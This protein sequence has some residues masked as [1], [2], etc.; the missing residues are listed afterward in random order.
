MLALLSVLFVMASA[1]F[2]FGLVRAIASE[3]PPLD[4]GRQRG[5]DELDSV[6]YDSNAASPRVLAVL[7][8]DESRVL[9]RTIDDVAPL[10]RQAIVAVEDQ[11]FYEHRGV[12]LRGIGRALWQ[13]I[14]KQ[15]VVEGG[16]TITQQFVKNAYV[17]NERTIGRKVREAALAWQL[18]Q[19]WSKDRILVA[20][21]N[22]IYF[23]NGAYGIQQAARTYFNKGAGMLTLHEAALLAGLPADPYRFDPVRHPRAARERRLYVLETLADQGR[24]DPIDVARADAQPLPDPQ[25]SA[26]PA[27]GDPLGTSSITSRTSSSSATEPGECS[28]EVCASVRRSTSP[29]RRRRVARSRRCCRTRTAPLPPSSRSTRATAPSRRCSAAR[30]SA[31]ASS[32]WPRRRSDSPVPPSSRSCWRR[33]SARGSRR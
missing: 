22:T 28:A 3:I 8:G 14:R 24:I 32:T 27:P 15:Q 31:A 19:R 6:I 7:R 12:D 26:C 1:A 13:D 23:G 10:M 2:S 33:P 9:V 25:T 18:E 20:Y 5:A 4:P 11:R 30:A 16:S 17:R 29:C 21:L